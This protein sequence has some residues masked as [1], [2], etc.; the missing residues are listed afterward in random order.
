MV[1]EFAAHLGILFRTPTPL[2]KEFFRRVTFCNVREGSQGGEESHT[3][4]IQMDWVVLDSAQRRALCSTLSRIDGS[5]DP[6]SEVEALS[7]LGHT[8]MRELHPVVFLQRPGILQAVLDRILYSGS[9]P[10]RQAALETLKRFAAFWLLAGGK[11]NGATSQISVLT[12]AVNFFQ[13]LRC[14]GLRSQL[15]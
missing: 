5:G 12:C 11:A 8:L 13:V 6:D 1:L 2:A 14:S 9:L 4:S 15:S 3:E 7:D 10:I